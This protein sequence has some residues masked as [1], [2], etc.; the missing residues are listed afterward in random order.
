MDFI[1]ILI[2]FIVFFIVKASFS[3]PKVL[4]RR[5]EPEVTISQEL[6]LEKMKSII[7]DFSVAGVYYR[8]HEEI[9][10]A[11][12]LQ[13][14]EELF[15]VS[16][17]DNA[18]DEKAIKVMTK[19]DYHIGYIPKY[20]CRMFNE[21][22]KGYEYKVSVNRLIEGTNAPFIYIKAEIQDE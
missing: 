3:K 21:I 9:S 13:K 18:Y 15:L 11:E 6:A 14:G 8:S 7:S 5:R 4:A 19:D 20:M 16:E 2:V 1:I 22:L 12:K 10:R 17:P